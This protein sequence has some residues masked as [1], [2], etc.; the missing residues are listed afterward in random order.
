MAQLRHSGSALLKG[1]EMTNDELNFGLCVWYHVKVLGKC[2]HE[3]KFESRHHTQNGHFETF[4]CQRI[5]CR[6]GVTQFENGKIPP[7]C[8]NYLSDPAVILGIIVE[9][10]ITSIWCDNLDGGKAFY[11]PEFDNET[12]D[13]EHFNRAVMLALKAKVENE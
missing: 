9:N 13:A 7:P 5:N 4:R 1:K 10:G 2:V 6:N 11:L 8:P 12:L 3:W